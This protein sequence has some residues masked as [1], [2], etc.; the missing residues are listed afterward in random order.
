VAKLCPK[1]S[2]N[3]INELKTNLKRPADAAE[4]KRIQAILMLNCG[5][6][7]EKIEMLTG[8]KRSRIFSLRLLY[9]I[10]G[11][12]AVETKPKKQKSLLTKKQLKEIARTLKTKTPEDFNYSCSFWTTSVLGDFIKREYDVCYKSK[13][14][15]YLIF[16]QAKF[17]YH[18]PGRVYHNQDPEEVKRWRKETKPI[19]K[20][21]FKDKETIILAEDEM[22]LSTQTTFQKI[23]LPEGEYPRIEISNIRKNRSVY[24]FLNVKTGQEHAFKTEWQNMYETVK[25]LKKIRKLYPKKKLLILWDGAGWHRGSKTQEFINQDKYIQT[26]YFPKYTPEENPQEHIWKNGRDQITHNCFIENIDTATDEFI[27]YL[28]KTT[29]RYSLLS[30]SPI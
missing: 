9:L 30:F 19:V 8:L 20:R 11:I 15:L 29:F 27:G 18:K 17:T 2:N 26:V 23:W 13:T 7:T 14:S 10:K 1:L 16:R 3:Q 6:K 12:K 28:N 21:A 5:E 4:L 25:I 22:I 24:G